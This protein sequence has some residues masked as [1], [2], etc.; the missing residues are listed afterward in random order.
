M[1][2]PRCQKQ[3]QRTNPSA[4][5]FSLATTGSN[6]RQC[7]YVQNF[8]ANL[9]PKS[10]PLVLQGGI[11]PCWSSLALAACLL[12]L[13]TQLC[14]AST[15]HTTECWLSHQSRAVTPAFKGCSSVWRLLLL[16]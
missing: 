10:L 3:F 2:N 15:P 13:H 14:R 5:E 11:V 1:G 9:Y 8:N 6:T 16:L 4:K 12:Q 7:V